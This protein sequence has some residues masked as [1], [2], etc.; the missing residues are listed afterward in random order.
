M[1]KKGRIDHEALVNRYAAALG[2]HFDSVLILTTRTESGMTQMGNVGRGNWYGQYGSAREWIV[3]QEA[4]T[5]H[6]AV[7][8][9][10]DDD[11]DDCPSGA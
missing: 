9:A 2:E 5:R 11:G 8:P 4:R 7:Q 1:R 10:D 3:K 6:R